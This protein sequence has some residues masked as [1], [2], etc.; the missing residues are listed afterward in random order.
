[1]QTPKAALGSRPAQSQHGVSDVLVDRVQTTHALG[2]YKQ[3]PRLRSYNNRRLPNRG[4]QPREHRYYIS[5][6][7]DDTVYRLVSPRD[8]AQSAKSEEAKIVS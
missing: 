2:P 6:T 8:P 7:Q 1:M 5:T 4:K 3:S